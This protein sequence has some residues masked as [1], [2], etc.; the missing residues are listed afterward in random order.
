MALGA[1][2]RRRH[3]DGERRVDA[4]HDGHVPELLVVGAP[5]AVGHRV[6][7]EPRGD[8][9][10]LRGIGQQVA[11][12]LL[13][14]ELVERQV[15]VE[16]P[17]HPVAI[18]PDHARRIVGV[19]GRVGVARQVEPHPRPALAEGGGRQQPVHQALICVRRGIAHESVRLRDRRRQPGQIERHAPDQRIP[20]RLH[21]RSEAF[22]LQAGQRKPVDP[23]AAPRRLLNRGQHRPTRRH[24]TPVPRVFSARRDPPP[25]RFDLLRSQR[26]PLGRRRHPYVGIAA[27][28]AGQQFAVVHIAGH[29]GAHA[30]VQLGQRTVTPVE[31]QPGLPHALVRP[32]ALEAAAG[33]DRL[34]VA[35]EVHVGRERR[36]LLHQA[37]NGKKD[38]GEMP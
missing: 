10:L 9:L 14:R 29:D 6:P 2:D 27:C 35:G 13:D 32:V 36:A 1:A 20:V 38:N 4:V 17:D 21:R 16:R 15:R 33:Q 3:P 26:V 11:G 5:L 24:V 8:E 18:L 30:A 12:K 22:A 28:H 37:A 7:V 23:V 19:A 34:D 25:Q 31:S